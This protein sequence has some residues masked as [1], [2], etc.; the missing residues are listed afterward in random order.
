MQ[1]ADIVTPPT[2]KTLRQF[3]GLWL[4]V[5]GSMGAW[6]LWHGSTS[7]GI[8]LTILAV[9]VGLAGL[10]WPR[11]VR[12]LFT[13]WMIAAFPIGWVVSQ[14]MLA[15]LFFGMFTPIALLFKAIR[16]D[17]LRLRRTAPESYYI[18]KAGSDVKGYFH[19]F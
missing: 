5:F 8:A 12:F 19:Q 3:A 18:E 11:A 17:A 7:W 6:R 1:W 10:A 13:G 9:V 14:L 2:E 15:A 4:V 16:R